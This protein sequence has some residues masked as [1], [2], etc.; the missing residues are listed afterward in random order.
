MGDTNIAINF[1]GCHREN[2]PGDSYLNE[3]PSINNMLTRGEILLMILTL[4]VR[5]SLTWAAIID[6]LKMINKLFNRRD[7]VPEI[8]YKLLQYISIEM[9]SMKYHF[10]CR[11]CKTYLGERTKLKQI[12]R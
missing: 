7:A 1:Q 10:Y 12:I 6:L 2:I 8:N 11:N 4:A 5:H 9:N 3:I